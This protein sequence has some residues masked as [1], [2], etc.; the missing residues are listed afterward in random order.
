MKK[1]PIVISVRSRGKRG[2]FKAGAIYL[3]QGK[4]VFW[5]AL[6]DKKTDPWQITTS[7]LFEPE[8]PEQEEK[9]WHEL[10]S[11]RIADRKKKKKES[12]R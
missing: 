9:K 3:G 2:T 5:T 4:I 6:R 8:N 1:A 10:I 7:P 12:S 11:R